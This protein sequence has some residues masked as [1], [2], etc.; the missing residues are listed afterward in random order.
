MAGDT[1]IVLVKPGDV[2]ILGN[3]TSFPDDDRLH[4]ALSTLRE[5][6]RLSEVF[7]F[8]DDIDLAVKPAGTC[9]DAS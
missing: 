3:V 9:A 6:L 1:R 8:E 4:T 5:R 7:V 2:L